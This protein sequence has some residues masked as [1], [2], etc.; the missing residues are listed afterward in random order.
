M[1]RFRKTHV[2]IA[3]IVVLVGLW[4]W[5]IR[6][7][8]W[9]WCMWIDRQH[10]PTARWY[11]E[12]LKASPIGVKLA[13]KDMDIYGGT[14]RGGS[15]WILTHSPLSGIVEKELSLFLESPDMVLS[16]KQM[17]ALIMWRRTHDSAYLEKLFYWI[18]EPG[19][20]GTDIGRKL[21]ALCFDSDEWK[22]SLDVP[23]SEKLPI[24]DKAFQQ[25]LYQLSN[26]LQTQPAG[27]STY[28]ANFD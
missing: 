7:R 14:T 1:P 20:L 4:Y 15:I 5:G 25:M 19:D 16:K 9:F 3:L 2:A 12:K 10:G 24:S 17:A 22:K 21:L 11:A 8:Y 23:Y 18:K 26:E 28:Q 6:E 13:L 27:G